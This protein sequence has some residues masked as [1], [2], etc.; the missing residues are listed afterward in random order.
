MSEDYRVVLV[1][2]TDTKRDGRHPARELYEPSRY[3]RRQRE[4]AEAH[5]DAWYVQSAEYGLV[6]PTKHIASYDTHA[7]DLDDP[8]RWA[9]KIARR[10]ARLE[11]QG[12]VVEILGGRAYANP[13]AQKL[14]RRWFRVEEPLDGMAIGLREQWLAEQ[15]EQEVPAHV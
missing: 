15:A 1:Q 13:L 4:Y 12:A 8:Y 9:E 5:A 6:Y 7:G 10:L 3:F 11:P 2:C 14:K